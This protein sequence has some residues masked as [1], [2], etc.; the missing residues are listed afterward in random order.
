[1]SVKSRIQKHRQMRK[2]AVIEY[3]LSSVLLLTVQTLPIGVISSAAAQGQSVVVDKTLTFENKVHDFGKFAES[4]GSQTCIFKYRNNTNV[5]IVIQKV[6][7]S[8]GCTQVEWSG[9]PTKPGENGEI[10]VLFS[11]QIGSSHFDKS[12]AVY[13]SSS[14]NQIILRVRGE[15]LEAE[16][17]GEAT[18]PAP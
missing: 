13:V 12:I 18:S 6:I 1:M 16:E 9:K 14:P 8:C 3:L 15:V 5:A 10:K 4:G 7:V 11:N 2:I 17:K